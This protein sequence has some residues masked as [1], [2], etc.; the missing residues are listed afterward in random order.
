M[1]LHKILKPFFFSLAVFLII[2]AALCIY[3]IY[4]PSI[5]VLMYH[6]VN[7]YRGDMVT[8]SPGDFEKQMAYIKQNFNAIHLGEFLSYAEAGKKF[9]ARTCV[10]TF[11]DGYYD[12]FVYA[13][14]VL[15]KYSLKATIF[16]ITSR[17]GE[18]RKGY[19][20]KNHYEANLEGALMALAEE[21]GTLLKKTESFLTWEELKEMEASGLIDIQSH[22]LTHARYFASPVIRDFNSGFPAWWFPF[23]TCGDMRLGIPV[24]EEE[25]GLLAIRYFDDSKLR[26]YIADY[27]K[28][29]G[30]ESFFKTRSRDEWFKEL[31]ALTEEYKVKE[32]GL[33]GYFETE[34]EKR[35]RIEKELSYSKAEIEQKLN[36]ECL[37]ICWPWGKYNDELITLAKMCGYKGAATTERGANTCGIDP[38]Y[39]KRFD[40]KKGNLGWFKSRLFIYSNGIF[41]RIYPLI[42]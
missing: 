6:H 36:K 32:R 16:V 13:Y 31:I 37:F 38:V 23:A 4:N 42:S 3:G 40:I 29:K 1:K 11:D 19:E 10:I 22:T 21:R 41:A 18:E 8:I 24:Y 28:K 9:P 27:V 30:G 25:K 15:K 2:F 17:M 20:I 12:N 14:P 5:P 35:D 34:K 26:E 33:K 39:I 7:E